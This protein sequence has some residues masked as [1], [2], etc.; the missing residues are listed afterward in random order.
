MDSKSCHSRRR[1][2]KAPSRYS[3]ISS[4]HQGPRRL[5]IRSCRRAFDRKRSQD[6]NILSY[7]AATLCMLSSFKAVLYF[8]DAIFI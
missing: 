3:G 1:L 6:V 2:E 4:R 5:R 7:S 8:T